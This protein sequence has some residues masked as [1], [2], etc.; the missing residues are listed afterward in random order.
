MRPRSPF[1][2]A[3][4]AAALLAPTSRARAED[5]EDPLAGL[6]GA[7][8]LEFARELAADEMWGRKTGF[9]G[10]RKAETWMQSKLGELGLDPA[11]P[12]GD[13]L[14]DFV[15]GST[16]VVPPIALQVEGQDVR[17]GDDFVD[18]AYT[19]AAKA[20][21]EVVFVGYGISAK[22]R[23]WDD[24]DGVDVK[25]KVVLAIRGAPTSR[26]ADFATERQI[27]WKSAL[28][29]DRGAVAFLI[30]EGKD[31]VPGT[32][33]E[34]FHRSTL[35]ALWVASSVADRILEK[36][37]RTLADLKTSRDGGDPG[38]SFGTG[39]SVRVE[40]NGRFHPK[41]L[42]HN[43]VAMMRGSDPDL[44]HEVVVV[45]AHLDHLGL[46]AAGR[47]FNGADDN[48]SGSSSLLA[49]AETLQRNRWRP[50]RTVVFAWFGA[51][52][53]GLVGS[54][55]LAR[56][57][58]F[59][60][61]AVVA[62]LNMDMTGQGKAEVNFGGGEAYP[63][64]Y[65]LAL[66]RL[67]EALRATTRPFRVDGNSDHWPFHERGVPA[68][69]AHSAGDH[70][71]Y[72]KTTDDVE[73][74]KPECLEAVARVVGHALV[75]LAEHEAPLATGR[76]AA[77][78]VLREGP[79]AVES[80]AVVQRLRDLVA[81]TPASAPALDRAAFLAPGH[82]VVIVPVDERDDGLLVAWT[83]ATAGLSARAKDVTLAQRAS[84]L[85]NAA[86][87]GRTA[88][89]PRVACAVAAAREPRVLST[90]RDLGARWVE[91]F[92]SAAL[93]DVATRERVLDA[94]K[95][96]GLV[97]D[98]TGLPGDALAAA[99]A[100]LGDHPVTYR[101]GAPLAADPAAAAS[102]LTDL[103]RALGPRAVVLVSGGAEAAL[104]TPAAVAAPDDAALA[105][106]AIVEAD[107]AR[108]EAALGVAPDE[109]APYADP[110][111]AP[112]ARL[113][114]WFG[115]ALVDLFRRF[116]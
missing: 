50:K 16:E 42:G 1:R 60:H 70:P 22:D 80:P 14:D 7:R 30:A 26:E 13:Y 63:A 92:A 27:G 33:Q 90:L 109:L 93:P 52:E 103:R 39:V 101:V 46:D 23:G 24:Y 3:V 110:E 100:R 94:A 59:P 21:A 12:D 105:P 64:Q 43:A 73:N 114:G 34:K 8:A 72:H 11:D 79:R 25:G 106:V 91:P 29:A 97:V 37:G 15:F 44:R 111:S 75:A 47:V 55:S 69:F 41:V 102:A 77:G 71:N 19:G 107:T 86:R 116:P 9:G 65:A 5:A 57:P 98:L 56:D 53:Q 78:Y 54:R 113:R 62:M 45:G 36:R 28:A 35:P 48:A 76:E 99:R 58:C 32:I 104:L 31:P 108:L 112:R 38:R 87:G 20:E 61:R 10:G 74:L 82:A 88:V 68:F 2:L 17:Y 85:V 89:L 51:E 18:L 6:S 96:A 66:S 95:A 49:L 84:D 40:V 115:Q 81:T 67:P 83:R 4:L